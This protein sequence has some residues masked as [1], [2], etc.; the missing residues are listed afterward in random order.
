[1]RKIILCLS[2]FSATAGL[3]QAPSTAKADSLFSIQQWKSA[4]PLYETAIKSG[5]PKAITWNR[6]GYCYHNLGEIDQAIRNYQLS[7]DNKP[8][9]ALEQADERKIL[10]PTRMNL[11]KLARSADSGSALADARAHPPVLGG[12]AKGTV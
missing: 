7:L 4:I 11:T 10:F 12:C 6:L 2:F 3:S 5:L 9:A 1:M 8:A